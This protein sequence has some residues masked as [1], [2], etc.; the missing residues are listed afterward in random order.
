MSLAEE[1]RRMAD[2]LPGVPGVAD[3]LRRAAAEIEAPTFQADRQRA[4][5]DMGAAAMAQAV[6][7][8]AE[9]RDNLEGRP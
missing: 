8:A 2:L 1:C 7:L 4:W 9:Q 3:L 6:I 5:F